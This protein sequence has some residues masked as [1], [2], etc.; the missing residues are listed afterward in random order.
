MREQKTGP[1][2]SDGEQPL[3]SQ[4]AYC[5]PPVQEISL[6]VEFVGQLKIVCEKVSV[7][8]THS[9]CT[10]SNTYYLDIFASIIN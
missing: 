5:A 3:S 7:H 9:H 2:S 8:K 6:L 1:P 10:E 4:N